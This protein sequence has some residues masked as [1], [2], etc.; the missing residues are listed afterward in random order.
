MATE[1]YMPKNGMDMTEGTIIRWLKNEGD[2]VEKDEPIMEIETDKITM[3]SESPADGVLLKKLYDDGA[4]VPVLTVIGYIGEEGEAVPDA[5]AAEAPAEEKKEAAPAAAPKEAAPA[6]APVAQVKGDG[7]A[8][9]PMAKRL[10]K[11]MGIDLA[12]VRP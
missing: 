1:V 6:A 5:P 4:V 10:A 12:S 7:V 8:A 11:E 2:R 9:T 3:E